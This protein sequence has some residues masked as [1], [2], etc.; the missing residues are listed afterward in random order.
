[1][2]VLIRADASLENG[3]GHVVRCLSLAQALRERGATVHFASREL[4][5][6]LNALVAARGFPVH[7]LPAP[8]GPFSP[9]ADIPH[10]RWLT[11]SEEQDLNDTRTVLQGLDGIDTLIVDHYALDARWQRAMRPL[12]RRI[13][14]I[15]DLADRE[16]DADIL[17]D[18]NLVAN[19]QQRYEG[20][21]RDD[22]RRLLGPRYALLR[23]EFAQARRH[24]QLRG[25]KLQRFLV[26]LGGVDA[27]NYTGMT[28]DALD[29]LSAVE[30]EADVVVGLSNPHAA[31][32]KSRCAQRPNLRYHRAV[33]HMAELM[34]AA[35]LAIGA[36]GSTVWERACL[37]LPSV[38][39]IVAANQRG[40]VHAIAA[41]G[42]AIAL[43]GTDVSATSLA[44]A[45]E[46]L[47]SAPRLRE[48]A[49]RNLELVDGGGTQRV[50]RFL[51]PPAIFLRRAAA[52]D[53]DNLF[54]W[55]NHEQ[56]RHVSHSPEPIERSAHDAW[57]SA[58]LA[59]PRRILL[60]AEDSGVP[61][62]VLRYD[63]DDAQVQATVSI[64]LVPN[65]AG[66]GYGPAI[67]RAG[68]AWLLDQHPGVRSIVAEILA[69]NTASHKA[70]IEA[71]Y[72]LHHNVYTQRLQE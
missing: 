45:I 18:Q 22:C 51:L 43:E 29:L 34:A 27:G 49:L 6:N 63:M 11:V 19:S 42:C 67:L 58:T 13:M 71:G 7:R 25:G 14:A 9:R 21:V 1:M 17:L 50:A 53:R 33:D 24:L 4:P 64:Y 65:M 32:I 47:R 15:D 40:S 5:G 26:F 23:P 70:F 68:S 3:T 52:A 72:A 46:S 55:R 69:G 28:L 61:V 62:G 37:G 12:A 66:Q 41:A 35:D 38:L 16:H 56:V 59:N 20:R 39:L 31:A 57:F 54:L 44:A 48:M 30:W 10:A 8:T 36:G 60:I 2:K